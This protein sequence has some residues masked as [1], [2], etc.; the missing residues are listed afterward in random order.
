MSELEKKLKQAGEK[1]EKQEK[2]RQARQ[3]RGSHLTEQFMQAIQA[4]GLTT[5]DKTSYVQV[6]GAAGKSAKVYM[7]KKG[8]RVDFS[9]FTVEGPAVVQI[10]AEEAK[11]KHLGR[12]R[13]TIDFDA[14]DGEILRAFRKALTVVNTAVEERPR[15]AAKRAPEEE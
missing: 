6:T 12:V 11:A 13:G 10:S 5:T 15:K 1:A 14:A 8:G 7:A 2:E 3:V 4:A 9:G